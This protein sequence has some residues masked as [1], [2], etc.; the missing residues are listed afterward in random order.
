MFD[1]QD[2]FFEE[3]LFI[4]TGHSLQVK[5]VQ[6]K[7]GG[8]INQSVR[9][10]TSEG[11]F[12]IKWNESADPTLFEAEVKGLALLQKSNTLPVPQVIGQGLA[13]ARPFLLLEYLDS[14]SPRPDYWERLGQGLASLH[15][16]SADSY[17]L[18]HNNF[19]G[20]LPQNNEPLADWIDFFV[21]R[22]LEP[23]LGLAFYQQQ[24]GHNFMERFRKL[25][26][27]LP[28][29][30][31]QEQPA[32]L[33]GDLWSGNVMAGADGAAWVFDP[34]AYWG[35][36][37]MELAFTKLFGG[38][39]QSFYDAYQEAWPLEKGYQD[40]FDIYN[41]YPLLVHVN[42]FGAGYLSGVE[43]ILNKYL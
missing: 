31:H 8:C 22:R 5:E 21:K 42:L 1:S 29:L 25:Y 3:A 23:Q 15:R 11:D 34:A 12:F 37:E 10:T 19:I 13:A 35:H 7:G 24:I 4:A 43:R 27:L 32:L 26:P 2:Q 28:K 40:R 9:L 36:R 16:I 33:H 30:L 39:E 18:D 41:L 17:G 14:R 20:R 6:M 38:F